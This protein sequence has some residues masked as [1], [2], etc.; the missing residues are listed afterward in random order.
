MVLFP[1]Q[2]PDYYS[3]IPPFNFLSPCGQSLL[4]FHPHIVLVLPGIATKD[5]CQDPP[6]L[7]SV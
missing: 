7:T 2:G 6:H 3:S 5:C 1:E 4:V